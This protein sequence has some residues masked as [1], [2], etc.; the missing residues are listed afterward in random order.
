MDPEIRHIRIEDFVALISGGDDDLNGFRRAVDA[1][2]REMGSLHAHHVLFDLRHADVPPLPEAIL[3]QAVSELQRR[4][5]GV[6][7]QLAICFDP[8][9]SA[10][11]DRAAVAERIA[12]EMGL[13]L[14][15]FADYAAALDWLSER[16]EVPAEE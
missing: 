1:L 13:R 6:A 15:A 8:A 9:D 16:P 14:R 7:N 3:V 5:L 2:V 12:L 4:G 11:A 10:R